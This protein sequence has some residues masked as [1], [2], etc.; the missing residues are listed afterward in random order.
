MDVVELG[1]RVS[2]IRGEILGMTQ[3]ELAPF[4][5]TEQ[6][7]LSRLERGIGGSLYLVLD[8]INYLYKKNLQGH[9]L[10]RQ[11]FDI[12]LF[13]SN[14]IETERAKILSEIEALML[15]S[16]ETTERIIT[17]KEMLK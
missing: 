13:S 6:A 3:K 10:F 12:G 17:L 4:L 8:F 9:M 15:Q 16:N 1:K 11:P 2:A 5:N 7:L 14:I